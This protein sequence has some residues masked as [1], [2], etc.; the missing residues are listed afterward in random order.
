[1]ASELPRLLDTASKLSVIFGVRFERQK[2]DKKQTYM[3]T[4]SYKLYSRVF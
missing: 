2:V 1:M 4:E 3:K